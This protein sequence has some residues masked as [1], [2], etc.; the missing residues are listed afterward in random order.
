MAGQCPRITNLMERACLLFPGRQIEQADVK[1]NLLRIKVPDPVEEQEALWA[2]S[3]NLAPVTK[4]L[5]KTNEVSDVPLPHPSHY[6]EWFSFLIILI[7]AGTSKM[8]KLCLLRQLF[9]NQMA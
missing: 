9:R 1:N 6:Q 2:A 8:L 3:T 4:A 5:D 7:C